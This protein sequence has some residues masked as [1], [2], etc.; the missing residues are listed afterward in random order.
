MIYKQKSFASKEATS[1]NTDSDPLKYYL[2]YDSKT[3]LNM[4]LN[5]PCV[6]GLSSLKM[7]FS[8]LLIFPRSFSRSKELSPSRLSRVSAVFMKNVQF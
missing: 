3:R 1:W 8:P 2:E 5:H 4:L 6:E 7:I